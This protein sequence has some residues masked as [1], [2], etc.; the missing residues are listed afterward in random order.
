[1][2]VENKMITVT[3][4]LPDKLELHNLLQFARRLDAVR[5]CDRF[6][7]D[8]GK[9]RHFPP[10]PML[11]LVAKISEFRAR[12]SSARIELLHQE[13]HSYAAHMGFFRAAG[14]EFGNEVGEARGS[15]RY[16]PIRSLTRAQL[17]VE[18]GAQPS[19][20][21]GDLIQ[22]HADD[23]AEM[24]SRDSGRKSD[25]FNVLSYSVRE[26]IRNVFEHSGADKVFYCAQY[27][28]AKEK[29][30]VCLLDRG[31]GIRQSL[32][33]NP[34]FRYKTDK[35]AVEMSLWPGVSGKTHLRPVS[36]NW[37]NSGYGLYMTSRLSRHG[38]NFTMA[39]GDACIVLSRDL[40]KENFSTSLQGTASHAGR[41]DPVGQTRHS[42]GTLDTCFPGAPDTI[43]TCDRCLSGLAPYPRQPLTGPLPRLRQSAK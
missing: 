6:V 37:A 29:V 15:A 40:R 17:S 10:F 30:E 18:S 3:L 2:S 27:W 23:I 28:P 1:M 35:E 22:V 42:P 8:M 4:A 25:F 19:A 20:E 16:L 36:E 41:C 26:M 12:H 11:F 43:R 21:L 33:T 24:I 9:E 38:G 31:I 7:L 14:F 13:A 32:G 34:N 39:S 5:E